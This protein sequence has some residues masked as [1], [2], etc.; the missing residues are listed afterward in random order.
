MLFVLQDTSREVQSNRLT[1][2]GTGGR[3]AAAA[4]RLCLPQLA[5]QSSTARLQGNGKED[6]DMTCTSKKVTIL[7]VQHHSTGRTSQ[8]KW[9]CRPQKVHMP[10]CFSCPNATQK[11]QGKPWKTLTCINSA[12]IESLLVNTRGAVEGQAMLQTRSFTLNTQH[13]VFSAP[14]PEVAHAQLYL[15]C[16]L[17]ALRAVK[18]CIKTEMKDLCK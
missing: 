5:G 11:R 17:P 14:Y 8:D 13:T 12:C 1:S 16:V 4:A 2:E 3:W 18:H 9:L 10:R 15:Y 6:T 7:L